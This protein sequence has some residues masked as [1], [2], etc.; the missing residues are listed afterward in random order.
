MNAAAYDWYFFMDADDILPAET[1]KE[2][3]QIVNNDSEFSIYK[4][5]TKIII[6]SKIINCASWYRLAK[7]AYLKEAPA[8][9]SRAR[10]MTI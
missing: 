4:M 2:I 3:R 6:N 1:I 9:N 10:C 8:Q 7:F 5:P